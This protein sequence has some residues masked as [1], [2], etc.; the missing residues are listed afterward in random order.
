MIWGSHGNE[1][2]DSCLLG[3]SAMET[4][5]SLPKFQRSILPPSSRWWLLN[6]YQSIWCYNPEHG[7]LHPQSKFF[8]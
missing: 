7:H 1:Y 6:L 5:V 4:G 3:C 8:L 2:E